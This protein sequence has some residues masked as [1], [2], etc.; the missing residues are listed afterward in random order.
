VVQCT[1]QI[2]RSTI[3]FENG[4]KYICTKLRKWADL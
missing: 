4:Q 3:W 2:M 1:D